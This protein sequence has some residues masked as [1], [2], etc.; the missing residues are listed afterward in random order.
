MTP[1][2]TDAFLEALTSYNQVIWP[3]QLSVFF[4]SALLFG[5]LLFPRKNSDRVI[6]G[7]LA[8]SWIWDGLIFMNLHLIHLNWSVSYF[9]FVF[10]IQGLLLIWSG[11]I[12][13]R[14]NFTGD[15]SVAS[16]LG[17]ALVI[18]ALIIYPLVQIAIGIDWMTVQYVGAAPTPTVILT[19]G[20]LLLCADRVPIHLMVIP[21][22]WSCA[23]GVTAWN[24]SLWWDLSLPLAGLLTVFF[25]LMRQKNASKS[26]D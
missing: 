25:S 3:G 21:V 11:I 20:I 23:D 12:K 17:V 18:F 14:L 7:L 22:V 19:L 10:A 24:L 26:V 9:G 8:F 2:S 5:L 1:Y 13:N 4:L 15:A 6:A 16:W